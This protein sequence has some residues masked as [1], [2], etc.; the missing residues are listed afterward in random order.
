MLEIS[1]FGL[2]G[3]PVGVAGEGKALVTTQYVLY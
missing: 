3:Q 2:Y 1:T